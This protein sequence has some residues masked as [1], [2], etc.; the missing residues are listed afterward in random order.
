MGELAASLAHELNQPLTAILANAQ[1]AERMMTAGQPD[2]REIRAILKDI[3]ADNTRAG[4][5]MWRMRGLAK[6]E[7]LELVPLHLLTV[8]EDVVLLLRSDAI[9]H[10][11]QI[12]FKPVP[13]LCRVHGDRVHLQQ[14]VLNLLL[15][16]FD[17]MKDLPAN[18][19]KVDVWIKPDG[20]NRLKVGV[21][22]CGSGVPEETLDRVFEPFYTT[23]HDGVGMGLAISRSIIE[24]HGGKLWVE[25]NHPEPGATF[26]FTLP[27][28][29]QEAPA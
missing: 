12:Q 8:I 23:K 2:L 29:R 7:N 28:W 26:Y 1:A 15:N 25:P 13:P 5:I 3:V 17:A 27:S 16:A 20:E 21:R 24:V 4:E 6:K 18:E 22:D 9:F 11:I 19:R 14:V 10:N